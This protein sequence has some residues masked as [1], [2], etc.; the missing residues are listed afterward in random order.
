MT[1]I[2]YKYLNSVNSPAD[3]RKLSVEELPCYCEEVRQYIIEQCAVNPG[4][5]ASSLGAVEI[6]VAIHYV[7]DTPNDALVWDV[8]H[9]AYTHK[10]LTGRKDGFETLRQFGGM[11]GFPK[12]NESDCDVFNTGHSSTSVSAALGLAKARDIKGTKEKID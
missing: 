1:H 12:R 9:Q 8:G 5:R 10:I 11:S 3:L 2:E 7:Y 4:H 6:A